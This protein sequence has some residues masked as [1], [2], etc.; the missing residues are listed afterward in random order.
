MNRWE[1]LTAWV[2]TRR[3]AIVAAV[4]ALI[5][6]RLSRDGL[7]LSSEGVDLLTTVL[8]GLSVYLVPNRCR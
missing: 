3:K 7:N 4:V 1:F 2:A 8:T 6:A 5:V